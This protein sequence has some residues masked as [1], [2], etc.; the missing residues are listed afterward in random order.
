VFRALGGICPK[1]RIQKPLVK[2]KLTGQ[3]FPI[4]LPKQREASWSACSSSCDANR[5]L[6]ARVAWSLVAHRR[7]WCARVG[8][9][10]AAHRSVYSQH[11][12]RVCIGKFHTLGDVQRFGWRLCNIAC[13]DTSRSFEEFVTAPKTQRIHRPKIWDINCKMVNENEGDKVR[14]YSRASSCVIQSRLLLLPRQCSSSQAAWRGTCFTGSNTSFSTTQ[15]SY[16]DDDGDDDD[17]DHDCTRVGTTIRKRHV[18]LE[19][20]E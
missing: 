10:A 5:R 11:A 9:R 7:R 17:H 1:P 19:R 2:V 18:S 6:C 14:G 3:A 8:W 20:N 16:N 4:E 12:G 15:S 13:A